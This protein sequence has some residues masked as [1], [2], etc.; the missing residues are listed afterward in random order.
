M[1]TAMATALAAAFLLASCSGDPGQQSAAVPVAGSGSPRPSDSHSGTGPWIAFQAPVA[2][3][4]G[5]LLVRTDGTGRHPVATSV[6]G[7]TTHP[8]WSADGEKLAF[9]GKD[10][11]EVWVSDA[12][13]SHA[14]AVATG[15]ENSLFYDYVAW[16]P[17]GHDRLLMVRDDG[18]T[19]PGTPVP[20]SSA[21]EL[22][23]LGSGEH[24]DVATSQRLH[25]FSEVS[26]SSDGRYYCA[27]VEI[28]DTG[29][30]ITGSAIT[31]G[32]MSGGKARTVTDPA[33]FAAYCDWRPS[34][35]EIVYTTYDLN[36]FG[37]MSEDSNLDLMARDGS[38]QRQITQ[39]ATGEKRATQPHWTPDGRRILF[40][41]VDGD[42]SLEHRRMASA[43]ATGTDIAWAT[44][45]DAQVGTHPTLQPQ[46]K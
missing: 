34:T 20:G 17:P 41:L 31:V 6:Q 11:G 4:D 10:S 16:V 14:H 8:A 42:G 33:G 5:I 44:G 25:L 12:D 24:H 2:G 18:P 46:R 19:L 27:G 32:A 43:S 21:L 13:G 29:A 1:W 35:A 3:G 39:F 38:G 7:E 30:G 15:R 36:V 23:D 9:V 45:A 37:D 22:L 26:V 40:T 28:G